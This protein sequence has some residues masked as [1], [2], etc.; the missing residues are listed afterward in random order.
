MNTV[1]YPSYKFFDREMKDGEMEGGLAMSRKTEEKGSGT[2]RDSDQ[3]HKNARFVCPVC[4]KPLHKN[5]LVDAKSVVEDNLY[6]VGGV[7]IVGSHVQ[8]YCNFQHRYDEEGITMDNPHKLTAVINVYFDRSGDY[9]QFEIL[10]ILA[11]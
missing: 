2:N 10:E 6:F 1:K 5:N 3:D 11:E 4:R 7:R 9:I 8:L